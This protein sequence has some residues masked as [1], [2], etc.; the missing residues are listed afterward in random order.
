MNRTITLTFGD[1]AE[2]HIGMQVIGQLAQHGFTHDDLVLAKANFENK[3]YV[4]NLINLSR[5]N[6]EKEAYILIVKNG[7]NCLLEGNNAN[8]LYT[9]QNVLNTDK[10]AFMYGRVVDKKARYNLCFSE[11]SQNPH[12]ENGKGRIIAFNDVPLTSTIRNKLPEYIGEI[13]RGLQCEGNYYYDVNKCGIGYHGDGER[14]KVVGVRIGLSMPL[15]YIWYKKG[16][17]CSNIL[18][19]ILDHGDI[20]FMS[21]YATGFDWKKKNIYTLRH[22]AGCDKYTGIP[23]VIVENL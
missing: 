8:D 9:E 21:E 17:P 19:I 20:Y 7:V 5:N 6:I 15:C 11:N 10:K 16:N 14:R 2:N 1:R 18:K 12:Y 4:C 23:N 13:G 22:A 3:G